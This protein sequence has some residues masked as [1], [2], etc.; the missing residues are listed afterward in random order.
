MILLEKSG[1]IS[2]TNKNYIINQL[3]MQKKT[4]ETTT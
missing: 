3:E 4:M 1:P 2:S